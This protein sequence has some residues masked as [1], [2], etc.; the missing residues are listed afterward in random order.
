MFDTFYY[1]G[2]PIKDWPG[3][4]ASEEAEAALYLDL[5]RLSQ[6]PE[7]PKKGRTWLRALTPTSLTWPRC[8]TITYAIHGRDS[9]VEDAKASEA[10][11]FQDEKPPTKMPKCQSENDFCG[12]S[13]DM[14]SSSSVQVM[15][16]KLLQTN[17]VKEIVIKN[18]HWS[19]FT[20]FRC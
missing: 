3:D 8:H 6:G 2:S 10:Y 1:Q 17:D 4:L 7:A 5:G 12:Q 16:R 19:F 9:G 15:T 20:F 18:K 11:E 13:P 14:F